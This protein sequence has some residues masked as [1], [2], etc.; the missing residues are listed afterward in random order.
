M[1]PAGRCTVRTLADR[2]PSDQDMVLIA[3]VLNE[4]GL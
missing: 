1:V 3:N 4:I 2:K